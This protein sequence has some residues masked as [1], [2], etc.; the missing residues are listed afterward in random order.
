MFGLQFKVHTQDLTVLSYQRRIFVLGRRTPLDR[1]RAEEPGSVLVSDMP[2]YTNVQENATQLVSPLKIFLL[3]IHAGLDLNRPAD[4][5]QKLSR[6]FLHYT[7]NLLLLQLQVRV[8]V[9]E[10]MDRVMD[11][12]DH[13]EASLK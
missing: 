12:V 2:A 9:H 13:P 10:Q 6:C 7:G 8:H 4:C 5:R 3:P 1:A 11:L